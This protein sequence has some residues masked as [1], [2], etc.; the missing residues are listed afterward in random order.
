MKLQ[1]D[2][3]VD[4]LKIYL[5]FRH[6][7]PKKIKLSIK[8]RGSVLYNEMSTASILPE[9]G[10][11]WNFQLFQVFYRKLKTSFILNNTELIDL[12]FLLS[13]SNFSS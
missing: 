5:K 1:I 10:S 11:A 6:R 13:F 9:D 7:I 3:P 2:P 12:I 8:Y 4:L